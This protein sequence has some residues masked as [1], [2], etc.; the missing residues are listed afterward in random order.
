MMATT[1]TLVAAEIESCGQQ[2]HLPFP[3]SLVLQVFNKIR[4]TEDTVSALW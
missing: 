4:N 1:T 2:V 3:Y